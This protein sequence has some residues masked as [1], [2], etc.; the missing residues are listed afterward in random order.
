M[1]SVSDVVTLLNGVLNPSGTGYL[2]FGHDVSTASIQQQI[3]FSTAFWQEWYSAGVQ[4]A[5]ATLLD[6]L[7][8]YDAALRIVGIHVL[9]ALMVSGF[10]YSVIELSVQKGNF[11]EIVKSTIQ[12]LIREVERLKHLLADRGSSYTIE[13]EYSDDFSP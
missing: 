4:S 6:H 7:I 2:F 5:K 1:A 10:S 8:I 13:V 3:T 12:S 9:G 11:P